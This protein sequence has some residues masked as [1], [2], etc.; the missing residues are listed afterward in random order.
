MIK[1]LGR[2]KVNGK[3]KVD[4]NAVIAYREG[5]KNV[6]YHIENVE[7]VIQN[8]LSQC[9]L[10]PIDS[11]IASIYANT[12]LELKKLGRPIPENDIWIAATCLGLDAELL[13]KD[14]HFNNV[15]GLKV[16]NW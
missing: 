9:L 2:L 1:S 5:I 3:L 16:I 12:R 4:T 15:P 6:C 7:V 11:E 14:S 13:T 10:M 8:F